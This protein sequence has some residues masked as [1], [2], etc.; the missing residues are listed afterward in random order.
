MSDLLCEQ[1]MRIEIT[2]TIDAL[3]AENRELLVLMEK[4]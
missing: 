4:N 2:T 3:H 1:I